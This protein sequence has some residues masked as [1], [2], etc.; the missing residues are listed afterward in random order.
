MN[1]KTQEEVKNLELMYINFRVALF[2]KKVDEQT[3][4]NILY[5]TSNLVRQIIRLFYKKN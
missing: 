4:I 3:I 1:K 5:T 2:Q